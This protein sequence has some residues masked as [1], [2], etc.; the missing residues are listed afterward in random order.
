[1]CNYYTYI[2]TNKNKTVLYTG[3]T[4]NICR[5]LH[6]HQ[7]GIEQQKKSFTARYNCCYLVYY[8]IHFRPIHAINREKQIKGW[9]REKKVDLI[10]SF[11]PEWRFLNDEAMDG[12]Y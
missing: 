11:N 5:R 3:M 7:Q 8:E 2:L 6:E 10:E 12:F 9:T 1:M 4:N